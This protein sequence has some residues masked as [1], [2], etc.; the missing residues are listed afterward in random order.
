MSRT[1]D[2]SDRAL[3]ILKHADIDEVEP[4][5]QSHPRGNATDD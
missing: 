1:S 2:P 5:D 3:E 4:N